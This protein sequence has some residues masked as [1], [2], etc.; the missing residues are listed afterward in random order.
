[1]IE[2]P[3]DKAVAMVKANVTDF[4]VAQGMRSA[5]AMAKDTPVTCFPRAGAN[6]K[7]L[8]RSLVVAI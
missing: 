4:I 6:T 7:E 2:S 5:A 1:M 8:M 3:L